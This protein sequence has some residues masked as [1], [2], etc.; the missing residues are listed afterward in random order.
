MGQQSCHMRRAILCLALLFAGPSAAES[1]AFD[2]SL[3]GLRV[4]TLDLEASITGNRYAVSGT[5]RTTR[6]A[7]VL[8]KVRYVAE[9]SGSLRDGR[10]RPA[11]YAED[12]DTGRRQS[13]TR[14]IWTDD[15]PIVESSG[16]VRPAGD[17]ADPAAQAGAVDPLTALFAGMRSTTPAKAC[18][19]T[20][21]VFDGR[22]ASRATL[23]DRRETGDGLTCTGLY[24]RVAGFTDKEM[25][26]R[27]SFPFTAIYRPDEEGRLHLIELRTET[28]FG[29]AILRRR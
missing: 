25:A 14:I 8:R 29:P 23:G 27:R 13:A 18:D 4:A 15:I 28:V 24:T 16:E 21:R 26:E 10:F 1:I 3:S 9:A 5:I 17:P 22:R 6:A 2:V 12:V 7:G 19:L 20:L 11:L